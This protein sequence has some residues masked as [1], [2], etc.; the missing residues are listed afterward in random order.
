MW[1]KQCHKPSM[2]GKGETNTTT[3][4]DL[5]NGLLLYYYTGIPWYTIFSPTWLLVKAISQTY[6]DTYSAWGAEIQREQKSPTIVTRSVNGN[7]SN[8]KMSMLAT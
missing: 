6:S 2:T 7:R 8:I 5:E 4:G 1:V 3:Y